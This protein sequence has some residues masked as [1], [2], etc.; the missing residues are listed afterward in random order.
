MTEPER[1]YDLF[2]S[3]AEADR[4]AERVSYLTSEAQAAA[5][6]ERLRAASQRLVFTNGIFDLLH[7]G[8]VDYLQKARALG[9]A[10]FVGLNSD[11]STAALKG[12]QRPIV[13][14]ADRACLL[15]AL[16]C[17]DAVILFEEPTAEELVARL[18]PDI[19]VKGGDWQIGNEQSRNTMDKGKIPPE[20][21][22]VRAYGGRVEIIPF[23]AG[24][25]TS[26]I[27]EHI[28]ARY[29]PGR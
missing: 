1:T 13:P 17:V 12:P 10:L 2:I 14:Q 19:Y 21:A 22:V 20:A 24:Y 5:H 18:Q 23:L 29:A 15:A 27:I 16:A 4:E 28:L 7:A 8:H 11:A 9:E 6:R 25:S 26:G 3:Y